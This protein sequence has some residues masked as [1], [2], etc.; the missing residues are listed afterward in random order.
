[1]GI[2]GN[3]AFETTTSPTFMESLQRMAGSAIQMEFRE[4]EADEL[5][6]GADITIVEAAVLAG[7][8]VSLLAA[9][10]I[11]Q[12]YLRHIPK[13]AAASP[14][15]ATLWRAAGLL[16]AAFVIKQLQHMNQT[17]CGALVAEDSPLHPVQA[18]HE[19]TAADFEADDGLFYQYK[20]R[21]VPMVV[22]GLL[23]PEVHAGSWTPR[24]LGI[25][26]SGHMVNLAIG[27][28][29]QDSDITQ[30]Q[31]E[32]SQ[33]AAMVEN[34]THAASMEREGGGVP[35][36][37]EVTDQWS[38]SQVVKEAAE[39]IVH[40]TLSRANPFV[41]SMMF[42]MG[43]KH[44]ITGL[45]ADTEAMNVLHQMHGSKTVWMF[46]PS[47]TSNLYSSEKY[48]N[49]AVNFEVDPFNPHHERF[50]RYDASRAINVTIHAGDALFVP[51]GWPHFVRS[52][53]A[54]VSLS[55]RSYSKC[56]VAAHV[57]T[58]AL[59]ILHRIGWYKDR[60]HCACHISRR[61]HSNHTLH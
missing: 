14:V 43:P 51:Y 55:G 21:G 19:Q 42:W 45:H 57:P 33:F 5:G 29:E 15:L 16:A 28:A 56:E 27:N 10:K 52:E 40:R 35:Y 6:I 2:A 1:M 50:P 30:M 49:G 18:V 23:Q 61:E 37:A 20:A 59:S 4:D 7:V 48:D 36:L 47:Q 8:V 34:D 38:K 60:D 54:S 26:Y 31:M 41:T 32:F 44:T 58:I 12:L 13:S 25:Q 53:S 39:A 17:G 24:A 9:A 22:R 3:I 46:P 11:T